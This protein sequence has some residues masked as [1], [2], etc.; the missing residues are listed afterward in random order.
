ML[1][2]A[3]AAVIVLLYLLKPR[4]RRVV[5]A[6]N[7]IWN[8]VLA[9]TSAVTQ[10]WRWLLSLLLASLIGLGIALALT[11][12]EVR[13]LGGEA[14]R[15]ALVLDNAPSMA[16]RTKDGASR[17][18]RAQDVARAIIG[19]AGIAS[20]FLVTDTMGFAGAPGYMERAAALAQIERLPIAVTG[21]ARFPALPAGS[22]FNA[23]LD[24]YLIS[25]GVAEYPVP[26][27]VIARSVFEPADNVALIAFDARALPNDPTRYQAFL[28]VS[29]ASLEPKQVSLEVTG[30]GGFAA[31]R[32]FEV[33]AG[34]VSDQI[35]DVSQFAGGVLRASVKT[36]G[37]AF[38]LDNDAYALVQTHNTKR[39]LLVTAGNPYLQDALRLLPGVQLT[40][41][42]PAKYR[43]EDS[44]AKFDVAVFD[45]F[46][47]N[48]PPAVP[49][50]L[51]RPPKA[52][53]LPETGVPATK[54][55]ITRWDEENPLAMGFAWKDL[56]LERAVL[57]KLPDNADSDQ[58]V[59]VVARGANEGALVLASDSEL[60][61][62]QI[63]FA[64]EDSNLQFQADF[65]VFLGSALR[66]LTATTPAQIRSIG[67]IEVVARDAVVSDVDGKKVQSV[68]A[69]AR[70]VFA[71][72]RPNVFSVK[73]PAREFKVVANVVD[74][75]FAQ[76]NNTRLADAPEAVAA[77]Q[78][79]RGSDWHPWMLLLLLATVLMAV[80]AL[81]YHRRVT[82]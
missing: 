54:P 10:R 34:K 24:R 64:L 63:G 12:P 65:P 70:T 32:S 62:V 57:T 26:E 79:A 71:A 74:P 56:Q 15:I 16:A 20:Q 25:D 33:G 52:A 9:Q 13:A 27:G 17:F 31:T 50:L 44:S 55:V 22:D 11:Q 47:P 46:A 18:R 68:A 76:I 58:Q 67:P 49:V 61:W 45:R 73:T 38:S 14:K 80:E 41:V 3:V 30:A 29:N 21:K 36:G 4:A 39:L 48:S 60:R 77:A 78:A 35:I 66:W 42:A 19:Q 28:Q 75:S 51:F 59:V 5:V 53:W 69:G 72:N 8:R 23:K 43:P 7:L 2:G 40:T 81:L 37:D 6:S 82:L 1:L